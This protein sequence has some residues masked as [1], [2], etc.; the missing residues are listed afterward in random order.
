MEV[1][2]GRLIDL[3]CMDYQGWVVGLENEW[4]DDTSAH[5]TNRPTT[6]AVPVPIMTTPST[7]LTIPLH[8]AYIQN[9]GEASLFLQGWSP[10]NSLGNRIRT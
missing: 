7:H 1:V 5:Q 4:V 8:V 2:V 9:L 6:V 10:S 3:Y